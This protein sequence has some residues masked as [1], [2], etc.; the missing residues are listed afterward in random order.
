MAKKT[1]KIELWQFARGAGDGG[2]SVSYF[3]NEDAARKAEELYQN[4]GGSLSGD[5]VNSITLK[6]DENMK[7][8]N[9]K[10]ETY[11]VDT[12]EEQS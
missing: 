6:F 12:G 8:I 1:L 9:G 2:C 11:D 10:N 4:D 3:N 7:L 5:E